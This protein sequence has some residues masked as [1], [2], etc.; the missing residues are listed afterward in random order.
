MCRRPFHPSEGQKHRRRRRVRDRSGPADP[1]HHHLHGTH[2]R[3]PTSSLSRQIQRVR[4]QLPSPEP[5]STLPA[6]ADSRAAAGLPRADRPTGSTSYGSP[7]R[8]TAC[9]MTPT[10]YSHHCAS[11]PRRISTI[12]PLEAPTTH[13]EKPTPQPGSSHGTSR[14]NPQSSF[15]QE[16]TTTT[17]L[18]RSSW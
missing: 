16:S 8:S 14:D 4:A 15:Q 1:T 17:C 12:A 13:S 10:S 7:G 9:S 3:V 2:Q 6:V 11:R 18:Q 5:S